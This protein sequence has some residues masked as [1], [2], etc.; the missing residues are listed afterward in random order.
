MILP[1]R[2]SNLD[3][4][5]DTRF[6]IIRLWTMTDCDEPC[7]SPKW[8]GCLDVPWGIEFINR[9]ADRVVFTWG[10]NQ[11]LGDPFFLSIQTNDPVKKGDSVKVIGV[12]NQSV[13]SPIL[14][15]KLQ[16]YRIL[17]RDHLNTRQ[18]VVFGCLLDF[19]TG[20]LLVTTSEATD[21]KCIVADNICVIYDDTL[22]RQISAFAS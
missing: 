4:F 17:N 12:D 5:V 7:S 6:N 2:L 3:T 14:D 11:A 20:P 18:P 19:D 8:P 21:P 22:I 16:S 9:T 1:D 10:E 13:L 15:A